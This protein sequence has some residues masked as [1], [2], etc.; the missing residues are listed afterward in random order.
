MTAAFVANL[1]I[2]ILP[3]CCLALLVA[4]GFQ[5]DLGEPECAG[6]ALYRNITARYEQEQRDAGRHA[7]IQAARRARHERRVEDDEWK[8]NTQDWDAKVLA[9]LAEALEPEPVRRSVF[10]TP[11]VA[12]EWVRT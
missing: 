5:L 9:F 8:F 12:D 1:A 11:E 6:P 4:V 7:E 10:G 3:I 2:V